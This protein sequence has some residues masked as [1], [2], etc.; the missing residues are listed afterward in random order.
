L[1]EAT[2]LAAGGCN[3]IPLAPPNLNLDAGVAESF[4]K[5]LDGRGTRRLI[6]ESC[7]PIEGDYVQQGGSAVQALCKRVRVLHRVVHAGK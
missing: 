5:S 7:D 3:F 1:D 6:R 4:T 2:K